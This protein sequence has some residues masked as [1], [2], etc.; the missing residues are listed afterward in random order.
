[1]G[2][3]MLHFLFDS[4]RQNNE[5]EHGTSI[6]LACACA[7]ICVFLWLYRLSYSLFLP[8]EFHRYLVLLLLG[9]C[10]AYGCLRCLLSCFASL[11]FV[12]YLRL[13]YLTH[14]ICWTFSFVPCL[15]ENNQRP[16]KY[17]LP[18]ICSRP[19]YSCIFLLMLFWDC[20]FRSDSYKP[21]HLL[22]QTFVLCLVSMCRAYLLFR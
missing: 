3:L 11:M 13:R 10:S 14:F 4:F 17:S 7:A 9:S 19:V 6:E 8:L 1:M 16:K 22:S 15:P 2:C 21:F 20:S 18:S 12:V 5:G